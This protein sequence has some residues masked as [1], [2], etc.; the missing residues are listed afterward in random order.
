MNRMLIVAVLVI[1]SLFGAWV[2][3]WSANAQTDTDQTSTLEARISALEAIIVQLHTGNSARISEL[4]D[5]IDALTLGQTVTKSNVEL[6]GSYEI[7]NCRSLI[8]GSL[9]DIALDMDYFGNMSAT[10][11]SFGATCDISQAY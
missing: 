6:S 3:T 8:Y 2:F 1:A 9:G 5:Q 10:L 4:E 7:S 11:E